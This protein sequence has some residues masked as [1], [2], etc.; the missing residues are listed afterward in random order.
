MPS[1]ALQERWDVRHRLRCLVSFITWYSVTVH[2]NCL[3]PTAVGRTMPPS[4]TAAESPY[5]FKL[6]KQRRRSQADHLGR[7]LP[8]VYYKAQCSWSLWVLSPIG[9]FVQIGPNRLLAATQYKVVKICIKRN[10]D[11]CEKVY[12]AN[13]CILGFLYF[14]EWLLHFYVCMTMHLYLYTLNSILYKH[15]HDTVLNA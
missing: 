3:P 7:K 14:Y 10:V 5:S 4:Y 8:M 12:F 1:L 11:E 13:S 6:R 2:R 15:K 9:V